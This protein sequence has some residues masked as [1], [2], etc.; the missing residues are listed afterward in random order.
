MTFIYHD[1]TGLQIPNIQKKNL[2]GLIPYELSWGLWH[3][4]MMCIKVMLFAVLLTLFFCSNFSMHIAEVSM[5]YWYVNACI[6]MYL[7]LNKGM[8][9]ELFLCLP[10]AYLCPTFSV[11]QTIVAM[12][13]AGSWSSSRFFVSRLSEDWTY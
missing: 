8:I 1:P 3:Y 10:S 11:P 6:F 9:R 5:L 7:L 2:S 12:T 4:I 13:L